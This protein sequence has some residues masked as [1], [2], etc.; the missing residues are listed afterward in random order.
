M[1]PS[2]PAPAGAAAAACW[3]CCSAADS[4]GCWAQERCGGKDGLQRNCCCA[5]N[6]AECDLLYCFFT[7]AASSYVT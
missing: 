5:S 3:H 7:D 6:G 1:L 2:L 4:Q